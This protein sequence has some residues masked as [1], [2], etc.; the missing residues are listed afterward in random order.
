M[1]APVVEIER[2]ALDRRSALAG[3]NA[4]YERR[5]QEIEDG[6][7]ALRAEAARKA[8]D[9]QVLAAA[10]AKQG[11]IFERAAA[12]KKRLYIEIRA[13]L[14][15]AEKSGGD[16]TAQQ[17]ARVAELEGAV[18]AHSPEL[19]RAEHAVRAAE[20]THGAA[21]AEGKHLAQ[22]IAEAG[23][24]RRALD[25]EFKTQIGVRS[26]GVS[27]T[28]RRRAEVLVE[29]MRKILA[30]RGRIADVPKETL[31]GIARAD[32][33]VHARA[34]ELEK[35]VRAIDAYDHDAYRRGII[36]G[37]AALALL[38]ATVAFVAFR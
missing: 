9:V 28:E 35:F 10:L 36:V 31:D 7:Q 6:A 20:A 13:I 4:E 8:A 26:E 21:D 5:A 24:H 34:L 23:R 38:I 33:A 22:R 11:E 16:L 27:E 14:D 1:F 2:L 18:A 12:K 30:A 29:V 32:E 17:T 37:A 15:T 19:E 3:T 25:D